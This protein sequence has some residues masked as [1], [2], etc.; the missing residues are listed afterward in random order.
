[1][2]RVVEKRGGEYRNA[3]SLSR[4]FCCR[5]GRLREAAN[6]AVCSGHGI[7][8]GSSRESD[9][10]RL[11]HGSLGMTWRFGGWDDQHHRGSRRKL[12][13][14]E[15][16]VRLFYDPPFCIRNYYGFL[17]PNQRGTKLPLIHPRLGMP[18]PGRASEGADA[19]TGSDRGRRRRG[20]A[21]CQSSGRTAGSAGPAHR[22]D[23]AARQWWTAPIGA[24]G[25]RLNAPP[26]PRATGAVQHAGNRPK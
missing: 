7:F 10:A 13:H 15:C 24:L 21:T 11:K 8:G 1:M 19:V 25:Q 22:S 5:V 26:H 17:A 6:L 18:E 4:S 9:C 14:T 2:Q 12:D 16:E 3:G 20:G 23:R